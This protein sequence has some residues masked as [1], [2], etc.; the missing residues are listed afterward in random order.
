MG[1]DANVYLGSAELA[2]VAA[3]LGKIPT[4][5]EYMEQ[6]KDLN[7]MSS[8]IYRYLNFHEIEEYKKVADKVIPIA[9]A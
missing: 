5:G 8:E 9:A 4:V 2:A 7:T 1:K 3:I 6:V